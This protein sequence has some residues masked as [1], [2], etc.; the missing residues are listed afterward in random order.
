MIPNYLKETFI[1]EVPSTSIA[2]GLTC[3]RKIRRFRLWM[4]VIG[5]KQERKMLFVS[6]GRSFRF[7]FR[8]K[9]FI[10]YDGLGVVLVHLLLLM[11]M[12][13]VVVLLLLLLL[14]LVKER[15]RSGLPSCRGSY[16]SGITPGKKYLTIWDSLEF[17]KP[18]IFAILRVSIFFDFGVVHNGHGRRRKGPCIPWQQYITLNT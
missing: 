12:W 1:V 18:F 4:I 11:L 17:I 5:N 13:L 15:R 2:F 6:G 8:F 14:L 10:V 16:C 7:S 3:T 9:D